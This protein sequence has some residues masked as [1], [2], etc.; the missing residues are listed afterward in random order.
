[1][2]KTHSK[3]ASF[4][5]FGTVW[6]RSESRHPDLDPAVFHME[7][8]GEKSGVSLVCERELRPL[9]SCCSL[10]FQTALLD[11]PTLNVPAVETS[12]SGGIGALAKAVWHSPIR[13]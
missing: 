7:I 12:C 8:A 13:T 3:K 5:A 10:P 1:M 6:D 11:D 9:S 4:T 2:R